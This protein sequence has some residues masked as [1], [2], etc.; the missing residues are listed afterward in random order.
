MSSSHHAAQ[1]DRPERSRNARA[2]ARHRAKRKAYIEQVHDSLF[3]FLS[4]LSRSPVQ[5]EQ[6]VTKLQL[7]SG[8]SQ[9]QINILPPPMLKIRELEEENGRLQ[10]ENDDLRRL[11]TDP[12][13][14]TRL[15]SDSMRRQP[16]PTYPDLRGTDRD[17]KRRREGLYIVRFSL[18]DSCLWLADCT[19]EP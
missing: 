19:S 17:Y 4:L 9:D 1:A 15:A 12:T 6:T 14:S 16:L 10:K 3:E 5:L 11:L 13:H 18:P 7:A 8:Y 2:Q